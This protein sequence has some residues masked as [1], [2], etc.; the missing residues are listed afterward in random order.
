M[1]RT[2]CG[3][4]LGVI[5]ALLVP[6][7]TMAADPCVPL[8]A[9]GATFNTVTGQFNVRRPTTQGDVLICGGIGYA[10]V[11]VRMH[12]LGSGDVWTT[13]STEA[14]TNPHLTSSFGSIGTIVYTLSVPGSA[15]VLTSSTISNCGAIASSPQYLALKEAYAYFNTLTLTHVGTL[16]ERDLNLTLTETLVEYLTSAELI[17]DCE[18]YRATI[19][20]GAPCAWNSCNVTVCVV[21]C[22]DNLQDDLDECR[23]RYQDNSA[24]GKVTR[25]LGFGSMTEAQAMCNNR[26]WA[27][28]S[29]C[30][31]VCH[32]VVLPLNPD[33]DPDCP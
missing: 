24:W 19:G 4:G 7:L 14:G 11:N 10:N 15:R 22:S 18:N 27:N 29:N 2:R 16:P 28:Y 21:C 31:S 6:T 9:P 33:R 12:L 20:L 30:E 23:V 3:L 13:T 26:A 32:N 25:W 8:G 5:A 1:T 17:Q